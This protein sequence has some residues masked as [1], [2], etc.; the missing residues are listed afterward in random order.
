VR[1]RW[2]QVAGITLK[3]PCKSRHLMTEEV[4]LNIIHCNERALQARFISAHGNAMGRKC[5]PPICALKGQH[6]IDNKYIA[7]SGRGFTFG[8]FST[9]WRC[10]GLK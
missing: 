3:L 2:Q 5:A 7:L 8:Q 1:R 10:H 6:N 9:P 4:M